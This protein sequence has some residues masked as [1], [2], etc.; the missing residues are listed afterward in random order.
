MIQLIKFSADWCSQCKVYDKIFDSVSKSYPELNINKI[1]SDDF[2]EM[3][4]EYK[5]RSLPTTIIKKEGLIVFRRTGII[6]E[7]ELKSIILNLINT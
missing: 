2:P 6:Q 5:I 1:D 4:E 3:V 7:L